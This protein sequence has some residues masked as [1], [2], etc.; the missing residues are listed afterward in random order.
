MRLLE[1]KNL[2]TTF[3]T[4]DGR[5]SAVR[6]VDLTVKRGARHAIIGQSGAGKS[7]LALSILGLLPVNAHTSGKIFYQDI[8]LL[9]CPVDTLRQIRGKEIMMVFQNPAATLNP[10]L[11]IETQL[12]EI[13]VHHEGILHGEARKRAL[14]TL[15]LC[16][17]S[18]PER[19]MRAYPFEL[20]GGML[21]RVA[22]ACGIICRPSL[23]MADEPFKGLDVRLQQQVAATLHRVCRELSITL[24]LITHSLKIARSLCTVVSVMV[25]GRIIETARSDTLFSSPAHAYSKRL[26]AADELF[27]SAAA[28]NGSVYAGSAGS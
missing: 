13:A 9:S 4:P 2:E 7:I 16:E 1:I 23:L 18:D 6:G 28:T 27:S 5:V 22:M 19:V 8:D 20:S 12:C 10:V 17:L 15:S 14:A 25:G 21:Q 26:I 24:L 3:D 11:S